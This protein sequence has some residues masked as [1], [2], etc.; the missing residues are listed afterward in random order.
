MGTFTSQDLQ[1]I[2]ELAKLELSADK[3]PDV[4]RSLQNILT[5]VEKMNTI[6]TQAIEP[7]SHPLDVTQP[8]RADIVTEPNQRNLFQQ[9]APHV[10]SGLYIV[11]KFVET[12]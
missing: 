1:K 5:F 6:D 8:L 12:E 2:T 10:E 11:P 9:N 4:T 7:L 3:I